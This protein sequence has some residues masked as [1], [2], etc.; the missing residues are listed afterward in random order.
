MLAASTLLVPHL[1][2]G[3]TTFPTISYN[4]AEGEGTAFSTS[5]GYFVAAEV[6]AWGR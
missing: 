1:E 5:N 4:L 2:A 3:W 6:Q